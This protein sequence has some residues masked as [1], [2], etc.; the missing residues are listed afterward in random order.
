MSYQILL[1]SISRFNINAR[2][3]DYKQSFYLFALIVSLR[4][5]LIKLKIAGYG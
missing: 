3:D 1:D 4:N 5:G 2:Y